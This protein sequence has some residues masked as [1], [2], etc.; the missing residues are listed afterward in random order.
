MKHCIKL[1]ALLMFILLTNPGVFDRISFLYND[2]RFVTIGIFLVLWILSVAVLFAVSFHPSLATRFAWSLPLSVSAAAAFGYRYVQGSEFFVFDVLGLWGAR[3]EAG[4]AAEFY[5]SAIGPSLAIFAL[6]VVAITIPPGLRIRS[7][8]YRRGVSLAPLLPILLIAAVVLYREGKGSEALPKQFSPLSLAALAAYKIGLH[9]VPSREEVHIKAGAALAD[10]IVMIVDES[11]RADFVSMAPG[12]PFTPQFAE[13]RARWVDFGPA[14][15]TGNCS[16]ISNALL[17]FMSKKEDVIGSAHT[18]PT[19]WQYAKAAGYR[20][21][22]IDAQAGFIKAYGKL[23]NYMTAK[24]TFWIDRLHKFGADVPTHRLDDDLI[25][26]VLKELSRGDKVFIYANKNG[27]HFP[28]KENAPADYSVSVP[29]E[30]PEGVHDTTL[31]PDYMRAVRWSTDRTMARLSR[32][33]KW[34]R[35]AIIYTADHGQNF[36]ADRLTHCNSHTNVDEQEGL[37]PLLVATDVSSL[38][39][40]LNAVAEA[41][42]EKA[43]HFAIA[44]ALMEMMG[45]AKA[46]ISSLY[47]DYSL[48]DNLEAAPVFVSGD[49][50]GLFGAKASLHST[51]PALQRPWSTQRETTEYE[52]HP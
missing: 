7:V 11:I 27:A 49:I 37:V 10:S 44:P 20:T 32:E 12:N 16:N 5:A 33:A 39:K 51:H 50:F 18:S 29:S 3:H 42:P 13:E 6:G 17:R 24:E 28:Y 46:D 4:R 22:Y 21:V 36:E 38:R 30:L 19:I 14:V 31:S 9:S 26:I 40:K 1:L 47:G 52:Q 8:F 45:Y 15:S 23:Q 41:F 25:D 43:S 2:G 34:D 48:L 35:T